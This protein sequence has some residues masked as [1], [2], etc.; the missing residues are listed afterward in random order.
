MAQ[1]AIQPQN[2]SIIGVNKYNHLKSLKPESLSD[3][4]KQQ[5]ESYEAKSTQAT[6][7]QIKAN[8]DYFDKIQQPKEDVEFKIS[9]KHLYDLF[10]LNFHTINKRP[11]I[12]VENVTI[13]NLEP[14]IYYFSKDERFFGCENLS[15][16]S[17]PSFDKGIL[18][19]GTYGNGKTSTMR[20]FEHIFKEIESTTFKGYSANEV[21]NMFEKCN[22]DIDRDEFEAR[23][24]R[25]KRFFD[26]VKTEKIASNY[27]KV[28]LF[29]EIFEERYSRKLITHATCNFKEGFEGDV[30]IAIEEF[31]EKYG[32]RVYDRMFDM[33]NIIEFK[34][35]SFRK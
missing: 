3:E 29:K 14:L 35:N 25:G 15:K 16:I 22:S 4:Q 33:F 8:F 20:V 12:K 1:E 21:V 13:K 7:E 2:S 9:A 5:I 34:G 10:K 32:N 24:W 6:P 31:G 23:M 28:N 30:D 27:G 11:F 19:V 26:D 17:V 18:L